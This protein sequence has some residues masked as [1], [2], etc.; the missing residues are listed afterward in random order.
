MLT[1]SYQS[2]DTKVDT[3]LDILDEV[4]RK[5]DL[6][7]RI[8]FRLEE[9]VQSA[10]L[11]CTESSFELYFVGYGRLPVASDGGG[12]DG[13]LNCGGILVLPR[14]GSMTLGANAASAPLH[15]LQLACAHGT[16]G[17][18]LALGLGVQIDGGQQH[19]LFAGL[20]HCQVIR[21]GQI[22]Q[23]A[24]GRQVGMITAQLL[25]Q[26]STTP[27]AILDRLVQ[28]LVLVV[29]HALK[30]QLPASQQFLTALRNAG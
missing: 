23:T 25:E 2:T 5:C 9:P 19:P 6:R 27:S 4:L 21:R 28:V 24:F 3:E 7:A 17:Q 10:K 11:A 1:R 12:F 13:D 8:A 20:K 22:Q 29:L 18:P 15:R 14:G 30:G 16:R 26:A